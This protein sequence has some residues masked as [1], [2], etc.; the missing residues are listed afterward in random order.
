MI[1]KIII[2]KY[3]VAYSAVES[4]KKSRMVI[5]SRGGK[6]YVQLYRGNRKRV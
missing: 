6:F 1:N 3:G 5:K 2:S 4:G